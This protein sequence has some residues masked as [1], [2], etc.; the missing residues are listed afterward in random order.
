[1]LMVIFEKAT[2]FP[3]LLRSIGLFGNTCS[4]FRLK[5]LAAAGLQNFTLY[6]KVTILRCIPGDDIL[7]NNVLKYFKFR[8]KPSKI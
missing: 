4:H 5:G 2:N 7:K 8:Y 3:W 1:M 6:S